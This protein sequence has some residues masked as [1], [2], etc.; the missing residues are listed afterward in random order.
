MGLMYHLSSVTISMVTMAVPYHF[1]WPGQEHRKHS[2]LLYLQPV[3]KS[4]WLLYFNIYSESDHLSPLPLLSLWFHQLPPLT[5]I[6]AIPLPPTSL[7][8][9]SPPCHLFSA[10]QPGWSSRNISQFVLLFCPELCSSSI[11]PSEENQSHWNKLQGQWDLPSLHLRVY[12]LLL[13][14]SLPPFQPYWPLCFSSNTAGAFIPQSLCTVHSLCLK[15]S[16]LRIYI[17]SSV[18][19]LLSFLLTLKSILQILFTISNF[20]PGPSSPFLLPC[21]LLF[22]PKPVSPWI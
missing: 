1:S 14:F 7:P 8:P 9:L 19:S 10:E 16:P 3:M 21:S 13:F 20:L 4:S 17:T 11:F 6:F 2:W 12:L 5:W 15:D 22:F 18:I